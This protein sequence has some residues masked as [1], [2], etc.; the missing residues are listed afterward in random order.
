MYT[1]FTSEPINVVIISL[2]WQ[3]THGSGCDP[4]CELRGKNRT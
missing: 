4:D 1:D 3:T 2:E